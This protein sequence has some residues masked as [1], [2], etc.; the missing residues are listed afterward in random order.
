M[1]K[2]AS[3]NARRLKADAAERRREEAR[4]RGI[5]NLTGARK[6]ATTQLARDAVA[7]MQRQRT[8]QASRDLALRGLRKQYGAR[9]VDGFL[10]EMGDAAAGVDLTVLECVL[11]ADLAHSL[12]EEVEQK[13]PRGADQLPRSTRWQFL[14]DHLPD[15]VR[16]GLLVVLRAEYKDSCTTILSQEW[17]WNWVGWDSRRPDGSPDPDHEVGLYQVFDLQRHHE[18]GELS[19]DLFHAVHDVVRRHIRLAHAHSAVKH[20]TDEQKEA[21]LRR[22]GLTVGVGEV[23]GANNCLADSLL[24]LMQ[25]HEVIACCHKNDRKAACAA[26]R[27]ELTNLPEESPL[28]PMQRDPVN[29]CPLV[30]DDRAFLQS[31]VHGEYIL[32][33]FLRYFDARGMLIRH[34]P[35]AGVHISVCSRFDSDVLPVESTDVCHAEVVDVDGEPLDFKLFNR[36]GEGVS[37]YHYDPIIVTRRE[38]ASSSSRRSAPNA[39]QAVPSLELR[40]SKRKSGAS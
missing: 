28:R 18:E 19:T 23:W 13:L 4:M 15:V 38:A 3:A 26:L 6:T 33:F 14:L 31:N 9:R 29:S 30:L 27:E 1:S 10:R 20:L 8:R 16:E 35:S 24:Q 32:K 2:E 40:R 34:L 17:S 7:A 22:Q 37:G 5:G 39:Q 11:A 36:T 21:V 12:E 25:E